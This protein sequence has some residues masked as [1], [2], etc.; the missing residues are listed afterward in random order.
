MSPTAGAVKRNGQM[1]M[2]RDRGERERK[3]FR[4]E[5]KRGRRPRKKY[6]SEKCKNREV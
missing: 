2:G 1:E 4:E 5:E 6:C 3:E